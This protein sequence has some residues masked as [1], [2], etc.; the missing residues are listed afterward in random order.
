MID[1]DEAQAA[2][3]RN[4]RVN[5]RVADTRADLTYKGKQLQ[6]VFTVDDE[7]TFTMPWSGA[8]TYER[9]AMVWEENVCAENPFDFF[10]LKNGAQVPTA[11]R[12]DF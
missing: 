2:M 1:F 11:A 12:P 7:N 9:P 3:T 5:H 8:I 6:V 4:L 10:A